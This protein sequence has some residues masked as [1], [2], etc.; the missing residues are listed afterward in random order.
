MFHLAV[1]QRSKG[2]PAG[3]EADLK[4]AATIACPSAACLDPIFTATAGTLF[5]YFTRL[6]F[7]KR[8]PVRWTTAATWLGRRDSCCTMLN[9]E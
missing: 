4:G 8:R 7:R 1:L 9:G 6:L 3:P 2:P 5:C